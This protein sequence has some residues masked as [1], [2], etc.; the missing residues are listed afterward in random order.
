[1]PGVTE[2]ILKAAMKLRERLSSYVTSECM[3]AVPSSEEIA[4]D[5]MTDDGCPNPPLL[6]R[7]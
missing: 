5:R 7:A 2:Q 4:T 6:R 3:N 1:V